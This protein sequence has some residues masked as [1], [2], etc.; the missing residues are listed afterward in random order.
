MEIR[1]VMSQDVELVNPETSLREAA[2]KMKE[3][4][5]GAIP[6]SENDR[7]VGMITDRDIAIRAVAEG[8]DPESTTVRETM[9]DR[10]LYCFEDQSAEEVEEMMGEAQVRRFPVLNRDKRLVG[11]VALGDLAKSVRSPQQTGETLEEVSQQTR[12]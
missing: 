1:E 9:S 3:G 2:R 5:F 4:D 10:I 7:L 8:K 6:V 12:H 11:I